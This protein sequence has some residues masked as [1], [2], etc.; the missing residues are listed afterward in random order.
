MTT[1]EWIQ[2]LAEGRSAWK[3]LEGNEDFRRWASERGYSYDALNQRQVRGDEE[4]ALQNAIARW[5]SE[6]DN[7]INSLAKEKA[8]DANTI[9]DQANATAADSAEQE[10]SANATANINAGMN[11]GTAGLLGSANANAN[12]ADTANALYQGNRTTQAATQADYTKKMADAKSLDQ[13][14][15][16]ME[17]GSA[18][19]T[20]GA[21][22]QGIGAGA[23]MGS[24]VSDE[25]MK[26]DPSS[27]NKEVD[28]NEL[29]E[30]VEQFFELKKRLDELKGAKE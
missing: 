30:K 15:T 13:Q 4:Y 9:Q 17:K 25:N 12:V 19:N 14:V 8:I 2:S 26:E 29:L 22:M 20:A 21:V 1:G 3:N 23:S 11:A 7:Y 5:N 6:K 10:A 18:L 28:T 27:N 16:N 24:A